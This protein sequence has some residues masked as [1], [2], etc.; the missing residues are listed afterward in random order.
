MPKRAQRPKE[1]RERE[2]SYQLRQWR[3][4]HRVLCAEA[5]EG[6]HGALVRETFQIL[7][8][9]TLRDTRVLDLVR[10]TDWSTVNFRTREILLHEI[11][12]RIVQLREQ[13]GLLPFSDALPGQKLNG[14]LIIRDLMMETTPGDPGKSVKTE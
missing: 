2:D 12:R 10:S 1:S 8:T 7:R 6:P 13:N 3:Q 11:N 5:L 4:W 9:M 14:F